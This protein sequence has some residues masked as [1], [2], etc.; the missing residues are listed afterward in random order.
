MWQSAA[1]SSVQE[2]MRVINCDYE[3][4]GELCISEGDNI[5]VSLL[6]GFIRAH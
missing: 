2:I 3:L 5:S 1:L 4:P 6:S